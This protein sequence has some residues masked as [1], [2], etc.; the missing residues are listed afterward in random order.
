MNQSCMG[1]IGPNTHSL[2]LHLQ[3]AVV[4]HC[5]QVMSQFGLIGNMGHVSIYTIY[6]YKLH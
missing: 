2:Y 4:L 1:L 6:L 5:D 3:G